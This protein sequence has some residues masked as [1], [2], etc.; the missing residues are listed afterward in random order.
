M[1]NVV[2]SSKQDIR[3]SEVVHKLHTLIPCSKLV[4]VVLN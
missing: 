4:H 1:Q 2:L 3:T